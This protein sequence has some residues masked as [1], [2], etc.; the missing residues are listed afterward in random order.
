MIGS[1]AVTNPPGDGRQSAVP[2]S[3]STRSTGSRFA[4]TTKEAGSSFDFLDFE[5]MNVVTSY[6]VS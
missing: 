3:C 2:S 5:F 6:G 4:T 1:N